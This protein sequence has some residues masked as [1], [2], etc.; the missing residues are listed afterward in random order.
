MPKTESIPVSNGILYCWG[1]PE[2]VVSAFN[3]LAEQTDW[4]AESLAEL[5][6]TLPEGVL[7]GLC[8]PENTARD[9]LNIPP[10]QIVLLA[11]DIISSAT[12]SP[13]IQLPMRAKAFQ[14]ALERIRMTFSIHGKEDLTDYYLKTINKT[15]YQKGTD[16]YV[17]LTDREAD[18]IG[19]L[20]QCHA[21]ANREKILENVWGYS[22]A[23]E[24]QTLETHVSRLRTKINAVSLELRLLNGV[25]SIAQSP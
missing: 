4:R 17:A 18:I 1:L 20:L 24:T 9:S 22:N 10:E 3:S 25:Y 13:I 6:N 23:I 14:E 15:L 2:V 19:F 7:S 5:P 8:L 21:G 16:S 11:S 12:E